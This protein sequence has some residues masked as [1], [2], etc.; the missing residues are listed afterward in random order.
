MPNQSLIFDS[1]VAHLR[2][3]L[4]PSESLSILN[5]TW[6]EPI[7][8]KPF[9]VKEFP[10]GEIV[11]DYYDSSV[12]SQIGQA[13]I[14]KVED[15]KGRRVTADSD[16]FGS[17]EFS[18]NDSDYEHLVPGETVTGPSIC[19]SRASVDFET[20]PE[21]EPLPTQMNETSPIDVLNNNHPTPE[22][23]DTNHV[24]GNQMP[25]ASHIIEPFNNLVTCC[26]KVETLGQLETALE[27]TT[28]KNQ[29]NNSVT[30]NTTSQPLNVQVTANQ[31]IG[32]H[33]G[34]SYEDPLY[35]N[36]VSPSSPFVANQFINQNGVHAGMHNLNIGNYSSNTMPSYSSSPLYNCYSPNNSCS[37]DISAGFQN[38]QYQN[39]FVEHNGNDQIFYSELPVQTQTP[40]YYISNPNMQQYAYPPK[41]LQQ[42]LE[43]QIPTQI[44]QQSPQNSFCASSMDS[45]SQISSIDDRSSQET[46]QRSNSTD[47]YQDVFNRT[48]RHATSIAN[49]LKSEIRE[50]ISQV[51]QG[52]DPDG[53]RDR[54]SSCNRKDTALD[55][56]K[57]TRTLSGHL[58]NYKLTRSE[59]EASH[60]EST[61]TQTTDTS[62]DLTDIATEKQSLASNLVCPVKAVNKIT[63]KVSKENHKLNWHCPPKEI[64]K[65]T[66]LVSWL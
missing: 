13:A 34:N 57:R 29:S 25:V 2:W 6:N 7:I 47:D 8:Q 36:E 61:S 28:H 39:N 46:L 63:K 5:G 42:P 24:I 52:I 4:L 45:Q 11:L 62:S 49:E 20:T 51:E 41:Y 3:F 65:P 40:G 59:S 16:S 55:Q 66:L 64:F 15:I 60:T 56:L 12:P 53:I 38:Y 26:Q 10:K 14:N 37:P 27:Q 21:P 50:V 33:N 54:S 9:T 22:K 23:V 1:E 43:M 35:G 44:Y 31:Y 48:L 17:S 19:F 58:L 30:T 32:S 18:F